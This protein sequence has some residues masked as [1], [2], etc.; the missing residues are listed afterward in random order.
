MTDQNIDWRSRGKSIEG[1]IAELQS[2]EDQSLE[3]RLSID[4]G[5]TSY[6]ISMVGKFDNRCLLLNC[7]EEPRGQQSLKNIQV[8]DGAENCTFSIFQATEEEFSL[9]FPS[10]DQDIEFAEDLAERLGDAVSVL[11]ALWERP[12]AKQ[13]AIGIHGTLFYDFGPKRHLFP[14][15]KRTRDWDSSALNAAQRSL[16]DEQKT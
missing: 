14:T 16:Y 15:T 7:E 1:L 13:D 8:I 4:E 2:F 10:V 11:S 12:I 5:C 3:V 6:V 9:L